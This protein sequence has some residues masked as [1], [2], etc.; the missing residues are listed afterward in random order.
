MRPADHH[1]LKSVSMGLRAVQSGASPTR[2]SAGDQ[3]WHPLATNGD[4]QV[5]LSTG[6]AY[7]HGLS[8]IFEMAGLAGYHGVEVIVDERWDTRQAR[9]LRRLTSETGMPVL[10]VHGPFPKARIAGWPSDEIGRVKQAVRL[11]EDV[12][13]RTLNVHVPE[14]F[15]VATVQGFGRQ[16]FVPLPGASASMRRFSSWLTDGGLDLL[17]VSTPV[18]VVV[19]NMPLR[20]LLGRRFDMHVLNDWASLGGFSRVCL[21]TTHAGTTGD[22][23]LEV[24]SRLGGRIAHVHLSDFDGRNQHLPPGRGNLPLEPFV[25]W[26]GRRQYRGVLVVELTPHA[27]P[28]QDDARLVAEFTKAREFCVTNYR[29]GAMVDAGSTIAQAGT[30]G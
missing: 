16:I 18:A 3:G 8:R 17:Q 23:L 9:Y 24:A 11:C 5:A 20:T 29:A 1:R 15:R 2:G 14:R 7:T 25:R 30:S 26:L 19:E 28:A 22:D 12:G 21:D 13:A 6:S 4:V 10:S 27:L